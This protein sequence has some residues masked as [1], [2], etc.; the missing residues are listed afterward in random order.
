MKLRHVLF[1]CFVLCLVLA[2]AAFAQDPPERMHLDLDANVDADKYPIPPKDSAW[3]ELAPVY[4]KNHTQDDYFDN[5]GDG[6]ISPCD[7]I[8][9]SGQWYHIEWVGPTIFCEDI[10]IEPLADI[11]AGAT[12]GSQWLE[13][14]P[15]YGTVRTVT[16]VQTS[17]AKAAEPGP[18]PEPTTP[19]EC[20]V[21]LFDDGTKC[22]V[23]RVG[24]DIIVT[25]R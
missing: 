10:V 17:S 9:L 21:I 1:S 5:D 18:E 8:K 15:N 25:P 24:T 14:H 20:D 23:T 11:T 16:E 4:C 12:L 7:G 22:H 6:L 19:K 13:V 2:P 3:H